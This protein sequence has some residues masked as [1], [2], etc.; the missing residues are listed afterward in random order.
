MIED[1]LGRASKSVQNETQLHNSNTELRKY[2]LAHY[3]LGRYK[4]M[5]RQLQSSTDRALYGG[6]IGGPDYDEV[7]SS[8]QTYLSKCRAFEES[9]EYK[10]VQSE[11]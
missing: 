9:P 8:L 7:V 1:V 3:C 11:V 4:E 2:G 6:K 5:S 10:F